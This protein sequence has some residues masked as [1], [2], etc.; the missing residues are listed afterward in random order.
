MEILN[1]LRDEPV[2][3]WFALLA[4]LVCGAPIA[5]A[6]WCRMPGRQR[7]QAVE[8]PARHSEPVH[9]GNRI[10][11]TLLLIGFCLLL[12]LIGGVRGTFPG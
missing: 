6:L 2:M 10:E 7:V 5:S 8:D 3:R 4:L 11:V 9:F 12:A 1:F